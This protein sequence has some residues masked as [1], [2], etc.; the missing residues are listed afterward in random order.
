MVGEY[1]VL[2]GGG[3]GGVGS[4]DGRVVGVDSGDVAVVAIAVASGC[5]LSLSL[6]PSICLRGGTE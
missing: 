6:L 2:E 4:G 5:S 3:V 1:G